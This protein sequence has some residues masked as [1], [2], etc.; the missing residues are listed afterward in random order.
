MKKIKMIG[1]YTWQEVR[2]ILMSRLEGARTEREFTKIVSE[3]T[4]AVGTLPEIKRVRKH[5]G[6]KPLTKEEEKVLKK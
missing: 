3:L 1:D 4:T 2:D 6:I 5:L